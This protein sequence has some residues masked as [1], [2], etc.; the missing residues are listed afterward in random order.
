M[1]ACMRTCTSW[2]G[3][4]IGRRRGEC[5]TSILSTGVDKST[6]KI[7]NCERLFPFASL[8]CGVFEC[9]WQQGPCKATCAASKMLLVFS[10]LPMNLLQ[11]LLGKLDASFG[12]SPVFFNLSWGVIM[13][14]MTFC[15]KLSEDFLYPQNWKWASSCFVSFRMPCPMVP[16]PVSRA[17]LGH[18]PRYAGRKRL[19]GGYFAIGDPWS[20]AA[21]WSIFFTK[22]VKL[23][24]NWVRKCLYFHFS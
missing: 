2:E 15:C 4:E 6:Q 5:L 24:S 7:K 3:G 19:L 14:T 18:Q 13:T 21:W 10:G 23:I 11:Q 22:S 16:E 9:V 1:H 8:P 17:V 12:M 20:H